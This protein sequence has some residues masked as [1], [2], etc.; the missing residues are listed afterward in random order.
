ML[1]TMHFI[2][3]ICRKGDTQKKKGSQKG[4]IITVSNHGGIIHPLDKRSSTG[5]GSTTT[6]STASAD[7]TTTS[8]MPSTPTVASMPT[9]GDNA[10]VNLSSFPLVLCPQQQLQTHPL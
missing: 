8:T 7:T 3:H 5:T 1:Q 6:E 2:Y 4:T 9:V 10:G